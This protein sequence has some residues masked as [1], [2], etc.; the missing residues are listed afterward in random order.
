MPTGTTLL[1]TAVI[2][3]FAV[4]AVA[5]TYAQIVTRGMVAPGARKP[6]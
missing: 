5:M 4:F 1:I 6:E 3:I 2:A